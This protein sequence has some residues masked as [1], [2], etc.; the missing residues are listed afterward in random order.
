MDDGEILARLDTD[1]EAFA[2]LFRRHV[3]A[4][5]ERAPHA[6]A[7]AEAFATVLD[8]ADRYRPERG[9]V[10]AWLHAA[11]AA[12]DGGDRA[13]RRLGIATLA[14]GPDFAA[15]LEEELVAAARFRAGRRRRRAPRIPRRWALIALA[16]AVP[17]VLAAVVLAAAGGGDPPVRAAAPVPPPPPGGF[18]LA[19][20]AMQGPTPC[21]R[22]R[23]ARIPAEG[24]FAAFSLLV[25]PQR[26]RD[27]LQRFP[28]RALP[29]RDYDAQAVRRP[30]G[31]QLAST[32]R[33]VP[34]TA[35]V[36]G[37]CGG[38]G[39]PGL[40]LVVDERAL[41]CFTTTE[42]R[43][44]RGLARTP[45]G[46]VVGIVPDGIDLVT[47]AGAP[48]DVVENVYEAWPD[49]DVGD[50]IG[51]AFARARDTGCERTVAP[52][53]LER[54]AALRAPAGEPLPSAAVGALRAYR[55][56]L[57]AIVVDG[58]RRWGRDRGATFWVVPIAPGDGGGCEAAGR[59]CV[60][61]VP[62]GGD[63]DA[64]CSLF[65]DVDEQW[66]LFPLDRRHAALYGTVPDDVTGA[67]VT[68]GGRRALVP[69]RANVL[70]GVL[71]FPYRMDRE[72][73]VELL[74]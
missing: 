55:W 18:A 73:R 65:G 6:D 66:R 15:Q 46:T 68:S 45:S 69:A 40:C 12:A 43:A 57:D 14:P 17:V 38:D 49:R 9:S 51:I 61:A 53:L 63:A 60:V 30:S 24:A 21:G 74:R 5:L 29:I 37:R 26:L 70:A 41:R 16:A 19:L 1:P 42:A 8:R 64:Q 7:C 56:S 31:V 39:G 54:V 10:A 44:G 36:R 52:G 35:V 34:T 62:A 33:V 48:A 28:A 50:R 2:V 59:A 20:P 25:R 47:V 11:A 72:P 23:R 67:R 4:V 22:P 3:D 58:A 27:P 13:R 32:V 71:P